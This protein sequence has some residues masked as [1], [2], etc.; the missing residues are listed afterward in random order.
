MLKK[1]T[2]EIIPHKTIFQRI[3]PVFPTHRKKLTSGRWETLMVIAS[4]PAAPKVLSDSGT[5]SPDLDP[6]AERS[7]LTKAVV[8]G[9]LVGFLIFLLTSVF[10]WMRCRREKKAVEA[11]Q[12]SSGELTYTNPTYTASHSDVNMDRKSFML[13]RLNTDNP[14]VR[15]SVSCWKQTF[16]LIST[17]SALFLVFFLK[18]KE[19][20]WLIFLLRVEGKGLFLDKLF[21]NID[22]MNFK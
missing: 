20:W 18:L 4:L 6:N 5:Q 7:V 22:R 15:S 1:I 14:P 10:L 19:K 9:V 16:F 11:A 12:P 13:R 3:N 17:I 21:L 2:L 8:A